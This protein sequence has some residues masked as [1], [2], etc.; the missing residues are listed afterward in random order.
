[1]S[2]SIPTPVG[3]SAGCPRPGDKTITALVHS[4]ESG[5]KASDL[6]G[7]VGIIGVLAVQW[8]TDY[9]LALAF[10]GAAE[11]QSGHIEHASRSGA[12]RRPYHDGR[13]RAIRRRPLG[14]RFVEYT[15][16]AFAVLLISFMLYVTFFDDH[17]TVP[18][19]PHDVQ[20]RNQIEQPEKPAASAAANPQ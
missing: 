6:S 17:Q 9:R 10:S 15:T 1:M 14:V 2:L 16:T 12:G 3:A 19:V 20:P 5:V 13:D 8:N 4:H 18:L 11:Y 7:P